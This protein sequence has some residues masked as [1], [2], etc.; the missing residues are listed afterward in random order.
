MMLRVPT[1]NIS[2]H[3]G[4]DVKP[5]HPAPAN[6]EDMLAGLQAKFK[7]LNV[8]VTAH[9]ATTIPT[10]VAPASSPSSAGVTVSIPASS[11]PPPSKLTNAVDAV[12]ITFSKNLQL[13]PPYSAGAIA[14]LSAGVPVSI[15]DS[16]TH[17]L[18]LLLLHL[19]AQKKAKQPHH[20]SDSQIIAETPVIFVLVC[21]G[22][23]MHSYIVFFSQC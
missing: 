11:A 10:V 18:V 15:S 21:K 9:T 14:H 1:S 20:L 4:E 8:G 19:L 7:S 13:N 23:I 22:E 6:K 16:V 2:P 12:Y 5:T 17:C 3:R